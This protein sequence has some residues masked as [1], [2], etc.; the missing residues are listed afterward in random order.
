MTR[1]SLRALAL[2]VV[3][4]LAAGAVVAVAGFLAGGGTPAALVPDAAGLNT[5]DGQLS[6]Y[7]LQDEKPMRAIAKGVPGETPSGSMAGS[8]PTPTPT[9]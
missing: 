4:V 1:P 3:G 6:T 5:Q 9:P 2:G 7:S 8:T